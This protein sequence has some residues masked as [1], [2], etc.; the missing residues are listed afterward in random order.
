M[1][2]MTIDIQPVSGALGAEIGGVD[3]AADNDDG[4]ISE[5]RTA[6]NEHGAI[7]F[8]DQKLSPRP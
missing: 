7:F 3:L 4:V 5:I 6:L 8:R 1:R 2:N